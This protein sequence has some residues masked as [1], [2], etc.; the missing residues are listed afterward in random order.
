MAMLAAST[1]L[2][3]IDSHVGR[4]GSFSIFVI[5]YGLFGLISLILCRFSLAIPALLLD[6]LGLWRAIVYSYELT[7]SNWPILTVLLF[8]SV[9]GGYVAGMLPFWLARW[10]PANVNLPWWFGWSLTSASVCAVTLIEPVMFIGFALLY[11]KTSEQSSAE[12]TQLV[13]TA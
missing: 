3:L 4:P 12:A 5:S 7:R 8:K 2:F 1:I 10:I 11:L 13:I 9:V 6:D